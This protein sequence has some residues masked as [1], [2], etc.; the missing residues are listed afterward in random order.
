[1]NL[2]EQ[3]SGA[4]LNYRVKRKLKTPIASSSDSILNYLRRIVIYNLDVNY[5]I[6]LDIK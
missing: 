4:I 6:Y 5:F 3:F 1:M 2:K